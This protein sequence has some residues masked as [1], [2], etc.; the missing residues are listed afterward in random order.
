[1]AVGSTSQIPLLIWAK[2]YG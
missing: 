2:W 1:L